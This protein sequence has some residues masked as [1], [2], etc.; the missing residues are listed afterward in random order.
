V[1]IDLI[2]RVKVVTDPLATDH[3]VLPVIGRIPHDR[4]VTDLPA[5]DHLRRGAVVVTDLPAI[6]HIPHAPAVATGRLHHVP[7][8]TVPWATDHLVLPA[9]VHSQM[10]DRVA[11]HHAVAAWVAGHVAEVAAALEAQVAHQVV[12]LV[13]QCQAVVAVT[14][15]VN[16]IRLTAKV[17]YALQTLLRAMGKGRVA[18]EKAAKGQAFSTA[19]LKHAK[20][21]HDQLFVLRVPFNLAATSLCV[22]YLRLP[23]LAQPKF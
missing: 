5:I 11:G 17:H 20:P 22:N 3:L 16:E 1:A 2:P 19:C 13:A 14:L 15:D 7:V 18:E 10:T 23:A 21:H 4:V 6:D 9:I 12:A 8:V